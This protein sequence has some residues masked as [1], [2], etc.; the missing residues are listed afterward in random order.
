MRELRRVPPEGYVE[1]NMLRGGRNKFLATNDMRDLHQ[2]IVHHVGEIIN[3]PAVALYE[4]AVVQEPIFNTYL[5]VYLVIKLRTPL[6]RYIFP[7]HEPLP[8]PRVFQ[9]MLVV[10]IRDFLQTGLLLEILETLW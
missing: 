6:L 3:R 2:M 4:D 1:H 9:A 10:T 5:A 7:N 8:A